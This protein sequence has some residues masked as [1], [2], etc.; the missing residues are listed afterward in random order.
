MTATGFGSA[1]AV[2]FFVWFAF[3][4]GVM[5]GVGLE[6]WAA[7]RKADRKKA[8]PKRKVAEEPWS[9]DLPR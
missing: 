3:V 6:A 2:V 7:D 4:V 1:I 8:T 5:C 9:W